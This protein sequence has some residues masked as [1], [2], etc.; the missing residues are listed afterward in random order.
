MLWF[1]CVVRTPTL[2]P[3]VSEPLR[4]L[5]KRGMAQNHSHWLTSFFPFFWVTAAP[6]QINEVS[7]D[8]LGGISL[9]Q[10]RERKPQN[11]WMPGCC[12]SCMPK[13]LSQTFK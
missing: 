13:M 3:F 4:T 12:H 9:K 2:F 8:S 5:C 10:K 6:Y 1:L 7:L 11:A